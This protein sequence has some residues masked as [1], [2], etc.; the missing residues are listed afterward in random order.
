M[1]L[2]EKWRQV[3]RPVRSFLL[4]GLIL[5]AAWKLLYLGF[6]LS[7]RLLDRP[8]TTFI[9][10]GTTAT[11]NIISHS[12]AYSAES[13]AD[14]RVSANNG[15]LVREEVE[16]IY[17]YR[18]KILSVADVCNGLELMV[19]YAGFIICWTASTGRKL[20]FIGGGLALIVLLN[21]LRCTAL[22]FL[23]LDKPQLVDFYHH[24][25]FNFLI[26]GIIFWLWWLFIQG[27]GVPQKRKLNVPAGA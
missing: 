8:L 9:G 12:S 3:P 16:R 10:V 25:V 17:R 5:F 23:Y 6:L 19:L 7:N 21:L 15:P 1:R 18:T 4:K 2:S 13:G 24:F 27:P 20:K 26:Y 22:V 14:L 11:L